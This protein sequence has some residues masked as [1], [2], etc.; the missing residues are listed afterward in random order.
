MFTTSGLDY[1]HQNNWFIYY[2]RGLV[3]S[4]TIVS[5]KIFHLQ[6]NN[7]YNV[8][9]QNT[10]C[11]FN[12][13]FFSIMFTFFNKYS[14]VNK[15]NN[16]ILYLSFVSNTLESNI[17]K[18]YLYHLFLSNATIPVNPQLKIKINIRSDKRTILSWFENTT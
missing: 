12:I 14:F 5:D 17:Y 9:D 16:F 10:V 11:Y 1:T 8:R 4:R 13:L 2:C 7:L 18:L 6:P 15:V 3:V